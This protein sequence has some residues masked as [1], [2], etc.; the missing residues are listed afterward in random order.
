MAQQDQPQQPPQ[1]LPQEQDQQPPPFPPQQQD[2]PFGLNG[3]SQIFSVSL[4]KPQFQQPFS[5]PQS[6]QQI[7]QPQQFDISSTM[8]Q[9]ALSITMPV[10][11]QQQQTVYQQQP[12]ISTTAYVQLGYAQTGQSLYATQNP[13]YAQN[14]INISST[15]GAAPPL[16]GQGY[17]PPQ[18]LLPQESGIQV[19]SVQPQIQIQQPQ[20]QQIQIQQQQQQQPQQIQQQQQTPQQKYP[21]S[22]PP[23]QSQQSQQPPQQPPVPIGVRQQPQSQPINI[24]GQRAQRQRSPESTAMAMQKQRSIDGSIMSVQRNQYRPTENSPTNYQNQPNFSV[25]KRAKSNSKSPKSSTY[26]EDF[27]LASSPSNRI[28]K[29]QQSSGGGPL[30]RR[31]GMAP[32]LVSRGGG[33]GGGSGS[34]SSGGGTGGHDYGMQN[35]PQQQWSAKPGVG[36]SGGSPNDTLGPGGDDDDD[37]VQDYEA[38]FRLIVAGYFS[39]LEREPYSAFLEKITAMDI[40]EVRKRYTVKRYED[41]T[42]SGNMEMFFLLSQGVNVPEWISSVNK[43]FSL[44]IAKRRDTAVVRVIH[45]NIKTAINLSAGA[46]LNDLSPHGIFTQ[47]FIFGDR[48]IDVVEDEA[49][50]NV[51]PEIF[52]GYEQ[53]AE[54]L[55]E[56]EM[57][58]LRDIVYPEN[59]YSLFV[60]Q[61]APHMELDFDACTARVFTTIS[62]R[63]DTMKRMT[64]A[65]HK[66]DSNRLDRWL[67]TNG[68][69]RKMKSH[70]RV[71]SS[72][73]E[74]MI[75]L[76]LKS[77]NGGKIDVPK[78]AA[79]VRVKHTPLWSCKIDDTTGV[80]A[81]IP[82]YPK[83]AAKLGVL[84]KDLFFRRVIGRQRPGK[85]YPFDVLWGISN[86][87]K[88]VVSKLA[89]ESAPC[90][91]INPPMSHFARNV[92]NWHSSTAEYLGIPKVSIQTPSREYLK[93]KA[94]FRNLRPVHQCSVGTALSIA[95]FGWICSLNTLTALWK[96]SEE[97]AHVVWEAPV[98]KEM[99][100]K[101]MDKN[102]DIPRIGTIRRYTLLYCKVIR[103]DR[104]PKIVYIYTY[105][106]L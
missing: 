95:Q 55:F 69:Y 42:N 90:R 3:P 104:T 10:Q 25:P 98:A 105:N 76:G 17:Q 7:L 99:L 19:S 73:L 43:K 67:K 102:E 61:M 56:K 58:R 29:G 1:F 50:G 52:C 72:M 44:T 79:G 26:E 68:Y 5:I 2:Q 65:C 57:R 88:L 40:D 101:L 49:R 37:I 97:I 54:M 62:A 89:F 92:V 28:S 16:Y 48:L 85:S 23:W 71:E 60:C 13:L 78:A 27:G 32:S 22:Q 70:T 96:S 15:M 30:V 91:N 39:V 20:Q 64:I 66:E 59:Q 9:P 83:K 31:S 93:I 106:T 81:C 46:T 94:W 103:A 82:K 18:I 47:A 80:L 6:Q 45:T 63:S 35:S 4:P 21:F 36:G 77:D 14:N 100:Q 84:R 53:E 11:A 74:R 38:E 33:G 34:G 41:M 86:S 12:G 8:P 24:N 87:E 51:S 75:F